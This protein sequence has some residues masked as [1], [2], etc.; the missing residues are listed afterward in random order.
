MGDVERYLDGVRLARIQDKRR[1]EAALC[2][3]DAFEADLALAK[4]ARSDLP[5]LEAAVRKV[6]EE[7][8]GDLAADPDC[9]DCCGDGYY[10]ATVDGELGAGERV[11]CGCLWPKPTEEQQ[12]IREIIREALE[13]E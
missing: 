10:M 2:E 9:A 3:G 5:R 11:D 6:W 13:V 1:C 12:R 8:E 4:V 7:T